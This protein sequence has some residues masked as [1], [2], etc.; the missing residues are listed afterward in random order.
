VIIVGSGTNTNKIPLQVKAKIIDQLLSEL[1]KILFSG[2]D[3]VASLEKIEQIR[4]I[5]ETLNSDNSSINDYLMEII[6]TIQ[7]CALSS[8]KSITVVCPHLP[9]ARSDKKDHRGSI[10]AKAVIS[11]FEHFGATRVICVD[12]HAAQ[13]TGFS[14]K[15]PIDN[16][17]AINVLSE[18]LKENF[19]LKNL[20]LFSPDEGGSKRMNGYA[21]IL[22][23]SEYHTMTKKRD[24]STENKVGEIKI[25]GSPELK[26]KDPVLIDDM[27][28]TG[29]TMCK[30][31]DVICAAGAEPATFVA[32]H[33]IFGYPA[34]EL[35][36]GSKFLKQ[37]I[38]SDSMPLGDLKTLMPKLKIVSI[39][40]LITEAIRRIIEGKSISAMFHKKN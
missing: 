14:N 8:A 11:M 4:S 40:P 18:S 7:G 10:G 15:M 34:I 37:V 20:A 26:G 32:T 24:Y 17:Y 38:V 36:N 30:A 3:L 13:I 1:S 31:A 6:F 39:H 23:I 27:I 29:N 16:L 22:K 21:E 9:Y 33:G 19:D 12:L 28:D 5:V 35:I 2:G 25:L